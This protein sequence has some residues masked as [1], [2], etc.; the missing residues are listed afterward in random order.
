MH[1]TVSCLSAFVLMLVA[2]TAAIGQPSGPPALPDSARIE[3]TMTDM[4]TKVKISEA[5]AAKIRPILQEN[6]AA[7]RRDQASGQMSREAARERMLAMDT[8]ITAVLTAEQVPLYDTYSEERRQMMRNRMREM[9]EKP[10]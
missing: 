1:S 6:M 9:Q 2:S 5:Q 3:Q 4:R 8:K 10:Q 7:M